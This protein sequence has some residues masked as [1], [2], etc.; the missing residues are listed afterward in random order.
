MGACMYAHMDGSIQICAC[1]HTAAALAAL[2]KTLMLTCACISFVHM[3]ADR[4]TML[5][6]TR[7][8]V[9]LCTCVQNFS[10]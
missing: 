6:L 4:V 10:P 3:R 9:Y 5:K 2:M 1:M 8:C 7:K